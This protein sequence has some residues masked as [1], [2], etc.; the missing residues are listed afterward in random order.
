MNK[1]FGLVLTLMTTY[2]TYPFI[3][4][5]FCQNIIQ[6]AEEKEIILQEIEV[7]E[8][9]TL[10]YI[11]NY[12]LKNPQLW[13]ELLK[14]N[15]LATSDIYAPMPG[16]KL[17]VPIVLVKEKFRPAHLVYLLNNV[18]VRKK[19]DTEWT[20]PKINMELYNDDS[21]ITYE[22][23]RANVKFYSGEI[24]SIDENSFVTIRPE[25][26]QEEVTLLQGGVRASKAKII[27]ES[28]TIVPRVDPKITKIDYKTKIKDDKTTL[29]EVYE[30][31]VDVSAQGKTVLVP[32]G[33]GTEIKPLSPPSPPKVLPP[34]PQL[35]LQIQNLKVSSDNEIVFNKDVKTF[36]ITLQPP[37]S[38]DL[39]SVPT[40]EELNIPSIPTSQTSPVVTSKEPKDTKQTVTQQPEI[41]SSSQQETETKKTKVKTL[42]KLIKKYRLQVAKDPEFKRIVYDE[43]KELSE[44]S[45]VSV[46]ITKLNLP[47]GK[48]YY[49]ISYIDELGFE[50]Y[51]PYRSF[52]IDTIPPKLEVNISSITKTDEELINITGFTESFAT[53]KVND[54]A[55]EVDPNGK[56]LVSLVLKL[57]IN[58][59]EFVAKDS[60]GNETKVVRQIELVKKLT[61]EEK[62]ELKKSVIK[63]E[64]KQN[65]TGNFLATILSVSVIVG[66]L[67]FFLK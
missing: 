66:V 43:I 17:K 53:V 60:A 49:K 35:S 10:S 61:K 4:S 16:M 34:P 51:S 65:L 30:G 28:A 42:G 48:Y 24:L 15:K 22:K 33:F 54:R 25:L 52:I 7:K 63:S 56:F 29:V 6:E 3:P 62:E 58:N 50:N 45:Q 5:A 11:A 57:G 9:Q 64:E 40:T 14:Y 1:K 36:N 18:K 47:D 19:N 55:V 23:S 32:K 21:L 59:I 27:T 20:E 31:A 12:Y 37:T 26:K 41:T 46:D 67:L 2:L 44:N 8:G 38:V 13:P 39:P